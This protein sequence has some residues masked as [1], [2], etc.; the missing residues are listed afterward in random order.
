MSS[1]P[2]FSTLQQV[3]RYFFAMRNGIIADTLRKAGSP[4]RIIFGL[5]LPQLSE[6]ARMFGP[7]DELA[8]TLW[9]NTSTRESMLLAPMLVDRQSFTLERARQWIDTIPAAEVADVL[10]LKLLRNMPYAWV[11]AREL[12]KARP[13][14]MGLYTGLRLAFNLVGTDPQAAL[15][16]ART[17]PEH[18]LAKALAEEAKFLLEDGAL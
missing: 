3:K 8:D 14:G 13:E 9:K 1:T 6:A 18:P 15:E 11:L 10:C 4:F 2:E 12:V 5:N 16:L 17:A 7:D